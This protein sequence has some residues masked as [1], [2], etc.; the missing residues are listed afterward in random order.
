MQEIKKYNNLSK[1]LREFLPKLKPQEKIKFQLNG[2]YIDPVTRKLVCPN[3]YALLPTDRIYDPWGGVDGKGDYV[4]LA[5]ILREIPAPADS[6]KDA[7]IEFG[8]I[9]F[10]AVSAGTVEIVGGDRQTEKLLPLLFFNNKN[11]TNVGKDWFVKP[12]GKGVFH[13]L[14]PSKK[15]KST[16]QGE[17]L[18][19][20]AKAILS[21]MS[22]EEIDAAA[23]GLMPAT[24]H[25]QSPDERMLGLRGIAARD[26][27][28]IINLSKDVEVKT[29][30]FIESCLK[31]GIIELDK[32]K[33]M[34]VWPDDK[35]KICTIKAG[36]TPHNSLKRYFQ[37]DSGIEV[38]VALEKQLELAKAS[39]KDKTTTPVV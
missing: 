13:Q 2:I 26:A 8:R 29:T 4:D 31:A 22:E 16:L 1:K 6:P 17:L 10:K 35:T 11:T 25:H 32:Q 24:Y 23:A 7:I 12:V 38:L 15:A 21:A 36:Q 34:F 3:S 37:T 30:S 14:E 18:I 33:N 28:K 27:N 39:K 20:K 19:D 9:A 5:Y